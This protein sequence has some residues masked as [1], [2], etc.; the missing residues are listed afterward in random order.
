[1]S[2]VL[3]G[4]SHGCFV[5][6]FRIYVYY[7]LVPEKTSDPKIVGQVS[8]QGGGRLSPGNEKDGKL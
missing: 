5:G 1:M 3:T 8:N 7:L 2:L 4:Q 6:L